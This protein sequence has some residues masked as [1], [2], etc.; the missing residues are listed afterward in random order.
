[1]IDDIVFTYDKL[2]KNFGRPLPPMEEQNRPLYG[3]QHDESRRGIYSGKNPKNIT[4]TN[5]PEYSEHGVR[6]LTC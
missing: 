5:I 6:K 4:L 3:N 2:R 1:M